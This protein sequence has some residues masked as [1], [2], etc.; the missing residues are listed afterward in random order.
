MQHFLPL[1]LA[2]LLAG[3]MNAVAGGGSLV[4]AS[5]R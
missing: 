3:M 2:G 5:S 4:S 1:I